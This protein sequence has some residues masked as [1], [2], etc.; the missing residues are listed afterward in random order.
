MSGSQTE[1]NVAAVVCVPTFR[2]PTHLEKTLASL[3]HQAEGVNFAVV[4][5]ENDSERREGKVVADAFLKSGALRGV[6]RRATTGKLQGDQSRLRD[7][8]R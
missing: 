1:S 8:S 4:V 6:C 3:A 7:R 2:R 5:V